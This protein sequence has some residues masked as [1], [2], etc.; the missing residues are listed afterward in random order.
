MVGKMACLESISR[1]FVGMP[2]RLECRSDNSTG[3]TD[4]TR[5]DLKAKLSG[6]AIDPFSIAVPDVILQDLQDRLSRVRWPDE[7]P[8]AGWNLGADLTYLR[9]LIKY[10][11]D[12]YDW[13][14]R[15]RA[16]NRY[17]QFTTSIRGTRVHFIHECGEGNAPYPLLLSHGWPGSI[18]EFQQLIPR[19]THPSAFGGRAEDAFTVIVPSLPGHGFSYSTGQARL[20]IIEIADVLADLMTGTLGYKRFAAHGHDWGAFLATR[21]GF[22]HAD[23]LLG[24]HITLL[25][26]PR[27]PVQAPNTPQELRFNEQLANWLREETGYSTMMG[28]KP[29]TL[30]YG[31]TD[32]P[33]GLAA[34]IIEKFRSW[35][36]CG[37]DVDAHFSRDVLLDNIMIYW[38][39]GAINSSFWPYYAR[40]HG[41]WIVPSGEKVQVPTGYAEFPREI[42]T[43]PRSVAETLYGNIQRWSSMQRGGHFP[44]LEDPDAL[45]QEI[46]SFF[47]PLRTSSSER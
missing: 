9:G 13:R 36:D 38:V 45:A 2:L 19:L 3:R 46:V 11:R 22:A 17:P 1:V 23:H 35:S 30:S 14:A 28:T 29:Q 18:V 20:G 15:E 24:I 42:L 32:S 31:L 39:T 7:V 21:L 43:P 27:E 4:M 47:R 10:W 8:G 44:A 16:L 41:P 12:T 25:A 5:A 34:W 37:G 6:T 33:V 40:I 26:V